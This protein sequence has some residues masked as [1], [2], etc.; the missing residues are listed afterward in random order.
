LVQRLLERGPR[1]LV[2]NKLSVLRQVVFPVFWK[3]LKRVWAPPLPPQNKRQ[4][5]QRILAQLMHLE[6]SLERQ[7]PVL[8]VSPKA[9]PRVV[10]GKPVLHRLVWMP[11][12]GLHNSKPQLRRRV[13]AEPHNK[14]Q[15]RP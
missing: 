12:L 13:W 7:L 1:H 11:Q 4:L 9:P 8:G 15:H 6:D 10:C 2:D 3:A 14:R 5:V